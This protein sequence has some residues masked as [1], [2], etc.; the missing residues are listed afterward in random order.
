PLR[1]RKKSSDVYP[2]PTWY[3]APRKWDKA[4][5]KWYDPPRKWYDSPPKWY[6]QHAEILRRRTRAPG[7]RARTRARRGAPV[8]DVGEKP[9]GATVSVGDRDRLTHCP[10]GCAAGVTQGH[11]QR[12]RSGVV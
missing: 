7:R 2:P 3:E 6:E 4:P 12:C 5:P 1:E 8:H 11:R 9:D 10:H